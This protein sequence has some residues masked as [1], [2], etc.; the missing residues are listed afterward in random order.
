M[1]LFDF[2]Q[3]IQVDES[4]LKKIFQNEF[5]KYNWK[6]MKLQLIEL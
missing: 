1:N 4:D 6:V 3:S 2:N 5:W